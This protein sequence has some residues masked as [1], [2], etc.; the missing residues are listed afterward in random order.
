MGRVAT[1]GVR[2]GPGAEIHA[3]YSEELEQLNAVHDAALGT[4]QRLLGLCGA[5][6]E[7]RLAI[8][9]E[10]MAAA[11]PLVAEVVQGLVGCGRSHETQ[12]VALQREVRPVPRDAGGEGL[13]G[14]LEV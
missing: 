9:A 2:C 4:E 5:E 3:L 10:A 7:G 14:G 13:G 11:G 8:A 1:S 12:L 6:L